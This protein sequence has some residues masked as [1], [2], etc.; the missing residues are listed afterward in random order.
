MDTTS[1]WVIEI[2]VCTIFLEKMGAPGTARALED[3]KNHIYFTLGKL[4]YSEGDIKLI[5]EIATDRS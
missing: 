5:W 4:G 2:M 1:W 3:Y